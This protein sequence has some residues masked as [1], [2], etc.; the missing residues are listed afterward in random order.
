MRHCDKHRNKCVIYNAHAKKKIMKNGCTVVTCYRE[1]I[2]YYG[3]G[4]GYQTKMQM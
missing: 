1:I 4:K 3:N 2:G